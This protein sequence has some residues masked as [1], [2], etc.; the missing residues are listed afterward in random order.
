MT[1]WR[2]LARQALAVGLCVLLGFGVVG[3]GSRSEPALSGDRPADRPKAVAGRLSEVAPPEAIQELR[4][5]LERYQPQVSI[6]SPRANETLQDNQVSVRF[7]VRDLPIY[8]DERFELG[9]H[10]HVILDNQPY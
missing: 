4:Q 6:L 1:W 2:K 8:K 3:C 9:P 10:L 7:Q 5:V